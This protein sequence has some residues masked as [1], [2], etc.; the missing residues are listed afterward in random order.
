MVYG[1]CKTAAEAAAATSKRVCS[2]E[3]PR[4]GSDVINGRR[5]SRSC[6]FFFSYTYTYAVYMRPQ[7]A[8]GRGANSLAS[9]TITFYC[10]HHHFPPQSFLPRSGSECSKDEQYTKN[11]PHLL[12]VS[13]SLCPLTSNEKILPLF[14]RKKLTCPCRLGWFDQQGFF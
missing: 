5:S 13:S 10:H 1:S 4:V 12:K 14:I 8:S 6:R 11:P 9:V 3:F 7:H 2:P